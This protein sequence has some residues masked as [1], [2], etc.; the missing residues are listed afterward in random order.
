MK[1]KKGFVLEK[2]GDSYLACATGKLAKQFKG[3][4]KLNETGAF[5]W[6]CIG[7]GVKNA[8]EIAEKLVSEYEIDINSAKGDVDKFVSSL[9][10]AGIIDHEG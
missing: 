8:D 3:Y 9:E 1:I 7:G 2:V 10:A 6:N 5:I 4:V